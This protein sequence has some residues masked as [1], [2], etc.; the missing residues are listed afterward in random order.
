MLLEYLYSFIRLCEVG[1]IL[2]TD[3]PELN[4]RSF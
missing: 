2:N 3:E 1:V 4:A